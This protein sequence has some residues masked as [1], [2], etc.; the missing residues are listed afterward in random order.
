MLGCLLHCH[1]TYVVNQSE[2]WRCI[3]LIVPKKSTTF[4]NSSIVYVITVDWQRRKYFIHPGT[5]RLVREHTATGYLRKC[6]L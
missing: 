4:C 6:S 3:V 2:L 1:G 5:D